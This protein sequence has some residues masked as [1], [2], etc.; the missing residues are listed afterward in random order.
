MAPRFFKLALTTTPTHTT[1]A[2][3]RALTRTIGLFVSN[4]KARAV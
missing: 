4:V 3:R 1:T 2:D